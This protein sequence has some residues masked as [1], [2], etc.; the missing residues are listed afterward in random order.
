ME[1]IKPAIVPRRLSRQASLFISMLEKAEIAC[2][3]ELPTG[4]VL[5]YGTAPSKFR[6]IVR[7]ERALR[8]LDE[9]SL[10]HAY[11]RGEIDF[12][13]DPFALLDLRSQLI[14]RL[15]LAARWRF[16]LYLFLYVPTWVN[17]KAVAHHY[18]LG[19]NFYLTFIDSRY[20]FYSHCLFHS[21]DE[22]LEQA[23]EHKL[24][25]M[26]RALD[27]RPGMRLLDIGGGWGGVSEYCGE[28]GIQVTALTLAEDSYRYHKELIQE[29]N[30]PSE[31]L[32]E[33]FLKHRPTDPYDAIVIYG[34]IEHI[35]NYRH[36][37]ERA[38]ECL[39]PG[40][41]LYMDASA[42][43]E[44][45]DMSAFTRHYIWR[46]TH[47]FMSLQDM[48]QE[49]LYYGFEVLE[50]KNESRD[51][52]LTMHHWAERFDANRDKIISRCGEEV[53][54]AFRTYLWGGCHAFRVDTLQAYHVVVRRGRDKGPRP[55]LLRRTRNFI[56][57]LA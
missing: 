3:L 54:R 39:R 10:G 16:L 53:Y 34:V 40:G 43:K 29:K 52:E 17:R 5:R 32:L 2:E 12:E 57:G 38:Y 49:L 7:S 23:S 18:T 31:V 26:Y 47:T 19:D 20:R 48:I 50:V 24:E 28:R 51:Y 45:Y 44:K 41:C 22:T 14:D 13:G 11:V 42:T 55:G 21:D 35:P 36:F 6:L 27:L 56:R 25:S 37:C 9:L 30:L 8:G 1:S 15:P 4:E 46:G 33:D